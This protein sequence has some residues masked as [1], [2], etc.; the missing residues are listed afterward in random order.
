MIKQLTST[1]T[2]LQFFSRVAIFFI[3]LNLKKHGITPDIIIIISSLS[4]CNCLIGVILAFDKMY[5]ENYMRL[6]Q[7]LLEFEITGIYI[8]Q[9]IYYPIILSIT[10]C[11]DFF[12]FC[13][14]I[15]KI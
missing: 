7:E 12:V 10:T 15:F 8:K 4:L 11:M 9:P 3:I 13:F 14:F 2:L 5:K 6:Q 1:L